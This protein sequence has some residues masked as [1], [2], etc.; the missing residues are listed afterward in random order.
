MAARRASTEPPRASG[1][2]AY[3]D[4]PGSEPKSR[5]SM[6]HDRRSHT[7]TFTCTW[8]MDMERALHE[9]KLAVTERLVERERRAVVALRD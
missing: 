6:S 1:S 8:H 7:R 2:V 4:G 5:Q 3:P 9:Q